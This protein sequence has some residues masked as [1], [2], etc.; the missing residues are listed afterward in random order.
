M[1]QLLKAHS[2]PFAFKAVS[3]QVT[4]ATQAAQIGLAPPQSI[5]FSDSPDYSLPDKSEG[6]VFIKQHYEDFF[7][8][9]D[10]SN[11]ALLKKIEIHFGE[12]VIIPN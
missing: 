4:Q 1:P 5:D 7:H 9:G 12:E 10:I 8:I 3:T 11:Y 6:I 2:I